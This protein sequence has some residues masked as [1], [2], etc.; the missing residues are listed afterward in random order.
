L[1]LHIQDELLVLRDNALANLEVRSV[2]YKPDARARDTDCLGDIH[3]L[4]LRACIGATSK[5]AHLGSQTM[6]EPTSQLIGGWF[7]RF[8]RH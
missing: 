4:A 5:L 2:S 7:E 1:K 3:S 8:K 6:D